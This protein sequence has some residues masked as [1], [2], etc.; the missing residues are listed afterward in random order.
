MTDWR[1][2]LTEYA[3]RCQVE[4]HTD[5]A[6]DMAQAL[7]DLY[8]A[9]E[10]IGTTKVFEATRALC[11]EALK[12]FIAEPSKVTVITRSGRAYKKRT[13]VS[14]ATLDRETGELVGYQMVIE[15]DMTS[16][17]LNALLADLTRNASELRVRIS[18]VR[19]LLDALDRHPECRTAREAWIADGRSTEQIDLSA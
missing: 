10:P 18:V 12:D 2:L 8:A 3:G 5:V 6:T 17:E 19:A 13:A 9:R 7:L 1:N 16:V 14:R 11:I 4:P 15:W